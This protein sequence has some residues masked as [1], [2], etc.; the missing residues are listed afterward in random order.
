M[1]PIRTDARKAARYI[2]RYLWRGMSTRRPEDRGNKLVTLSFTVQQ[3]VKGHYLRALI[4]AGGVP[5]L[6]R[7]LRWDF[8]EVERKMRARLNGEEVCD[9]PF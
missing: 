8:E 9:G 6:M 3:L 7:E 2:V 1:L 5:H 4:A